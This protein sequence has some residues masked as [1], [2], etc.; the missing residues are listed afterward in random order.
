MFGIGST[1]LLVILVVALIVLGPKSIPQIAKTLG[2]AMGEFRRVS[3]EF[4]RTMNAEVEQEEHEKRKKEA[5]KEFFG[6]A[7]TS[8]VT[9]PQPTEAA[10]LAPSNQTDR[11]ATAPDTLVAPPLS[12]T[13]PPWLDPDSPLARAVGKAE[14][15]AAASS[16]PIEP[17]QSPTK[18]K[19]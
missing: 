14:A 7:S 10:P 11:P 6:D 19:A 4:Q 5:E 13:P 3:T 2:K 1:E 8:D 15:E 17:H 18:D 12:T 9:R 16:T